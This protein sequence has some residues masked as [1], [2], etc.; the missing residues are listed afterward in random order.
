MNSRL[1]L[2]SVAAVAV[3]C[4]CGKTSEPVA[5]ENSP[6][7]LDE[8]AP[9]APQTLSVNDDGSGGGSLVWSSSAAPDVAGYQVWAYSPDP[10][11]DNSY[12]QVWTTTGLET[13]YTIDGSGESTTRYFRVAAVDG[14]GN[15]S[16]LSAPIAVEVGPPQRVGDPVD[17]GP[18]LG[19]MNP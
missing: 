10:N 7:T 1:F 4:G 11:R 15:R 6:A 18:A 9:P 16:S 12:V 5:L 19:H 8:T 13:N 2:L 17:G 14:S 3:L